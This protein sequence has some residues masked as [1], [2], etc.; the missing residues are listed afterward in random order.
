MVELHY[1]VFQKDEYSLKTFAKKKKRGLRE[2]SLSISFQGW[3][4]A[5]QLGAWDALPEDQV[6][7]PSTHKETHNI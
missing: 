4:D 1:T 2:Y 7:V 6:L 3:R 5:Q